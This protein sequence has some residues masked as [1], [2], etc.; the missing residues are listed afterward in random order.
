MSSSLKKPGKS[1]IEITKNSTSPEIKRTDSSKNEGYQN[2]YERYKLIKDMKVDAQADKRES[3]NS[4]I[5]E[6]TKPAS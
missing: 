6:K 4:P 5:K 3:F 1:P 2:L